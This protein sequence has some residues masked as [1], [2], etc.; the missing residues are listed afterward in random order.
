MTAEAEF[1]SIVVSTAR[2]IFR[3]PDLGYDPGQVFQDIRGFDSIQAVQFI[4]AIEA[5]L[6]VMFSEEEVDNM[7]TMGDLV[8]MLNRKKALLF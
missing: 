5:A 6:D 2:S 3:A 1:T 8:A 4:L 7:R